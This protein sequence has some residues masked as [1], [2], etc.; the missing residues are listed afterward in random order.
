MKLRI[1]G[2]NE[3]IE[4]GERRYN[5]TWIKIKIEGDGWK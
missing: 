1:G 2:E 3:W 4:K 5:R